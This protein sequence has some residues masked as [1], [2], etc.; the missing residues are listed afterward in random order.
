MKK[1]KYL[2]VFLL[3][4]KVIFANNISINNVSLSNKN[5]LQET[6]YHL[7]FDVAW[8]N[9]WR[10]T[11]NESN[12]DGAWVFFKYRLS[13]TSTWKHLTLIQPNNSIAAS[14]ATIQI[15]SDGMGLFIYRDVNGTGNVSFTNN[16]V[17]W[18]YQNDGV[19]EKQTVEIKAFAI[20]MVNIPQGAFYLGSGVGGSSIN[21]EFK[22]GG[23]GT[24]GND[25]VP[26]YVSNSNAINFGTTTGT[27]DTRSG[28]TSGNSGSYPTGFMPFW[29]M[30][31]ECTI[32]QYIDFLNLLQVGQAGNL[33]PFFSLTGQFPNF[34]SITPYHP[35][36]LSTTPFLSYAD[37]AG[38]RPITETEF[39]KACRG[40]NITPVPYEYAWGSTVIKRITSVFNFGLA[41]ESVDT[42]VDANSTFPS[43]L[44]RVGLFARPAGASR[45]LSGATYYGVLNMSDNGYEITIDVKSFATFNN[46]NGDGFLNSNGT[47]DI[48]SWLSLKYQEKF[49]NISS[50]NGGTTTGFTGNA[51]RLGR[52]IN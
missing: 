42:P 37:W 52:S 33:Q 18:D 7:N 3:F 39:E 14:G 38:L 19:L 48:S 11:T 36:L 4:T 28:P 31:Y 23:T 13:N 17:I 27:L 10:T 21:S 6:T 16:Y 41:N 50:R 40:A 22:V 51:L 20:E 8:E 9:S 25:N 30:K 45:E 49:T 24:S 44:N 35:V 5:T 15:P 34:T 29:I 1:L 43:N 12:Y 46:L 26:Y 47:T 32:Q 2:F